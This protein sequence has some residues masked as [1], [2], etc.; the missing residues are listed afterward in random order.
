MDTRLPPR[1]VTLTISR[2]TTVS[3]G[4]DSWETMSVPS[5]PTVP[6][7]LVATVPV[8]MIDFPTLHEKATRRPSLMRSFITRILV[9]R[10]HPKQSR[11]RF[12]LLELTRGDNSIW[13]RLDRAG[14]GLLPR[15]L[16]GGT[17]T[18]IDDTV[19]STFSIYMRNDSAVQQSN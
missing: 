15:S 5:S 19:R 11:H 13:L 1:E 6:S 4:S 9:C 10:E 16:L 7:T 8:A 14:K 3:E 12:L 2:V 18:S 17:L